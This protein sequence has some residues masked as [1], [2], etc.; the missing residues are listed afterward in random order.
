MIQAGSRNV[1]KLLMLAVCVAVPALA[2]ELR[3]K[4]ATIDASPPERPWAKIAGDFNGDGLP[5]VAI[6]GSQGPLVWYE[7]PSW[8][9]TIVTEG[10]STLR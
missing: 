6:G 2:E 3:V 4:L 7:Y 8:K 9:K 1:S 10:G 5:D